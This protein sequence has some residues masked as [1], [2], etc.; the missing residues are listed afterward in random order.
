MKDEGRGAYLPREDETHHTTLEMVSAWP[1]IHVALLSV[2]CQVVTLFVGS[3]FGVKL[4]HV[5]DEVVVVLPGDEPVREGGHVPDVLAVGELEDRALPL[6]EG[7][8]KSEAKLA[9][10]VDLQ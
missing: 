8:A 5:V 10:E 1:R 7:P 3:L 4:L 6:V 2:S 9:T